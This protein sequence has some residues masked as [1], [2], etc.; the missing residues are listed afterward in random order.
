MRNDYE[1]VHVI[2]LKVSN[3]GEHRLI[4]YYNE[5]DALNAV[6]GVSLKEKTHVK[7]CLGAN[8]QL[9]AMWSSQNGHLWVV[10]DQGDVFTNANIN[11][12]QPPFERLKFNSGSFDIK[13]NVTEVF[14]GQLN[15]IWGTSDE[16]V[17][18][19]AFA[20]PAF[21][22]DG[23][24]WTQYT[25]PKAPNA[26]DGSASD[27][28]YVVGYDGNIH[29]FNGSAWTKIALPSGIPQQDAFTD[30]KVLS[31][32]KVFI[33]GRSGC[34]LVGNANN[35]FTDIGSAKYS[36]YGVGAIEERIFLAGGE[37]G[38]FELIDGQFVCL[39][40]K[41]QPVGVF[42]TPNAINFIPAEQQP[43]PWFVRYEPGAS[44]EWT[45]VNT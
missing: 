14:K 44:R 35:G 33:T 2:D 5:A 27:D 29:H 6:G 10:D 31:R 9:N 34:L 32:D 37:Q 18:V 45:K 17:W 3:L 25:L 22:W 4:T 11:F 15:A 16:D 1:I 19:T 23:Q 39:K 26:I 38:I 20:G 41:G 7:T 12:K 13:W 21:H 8:F 43:N 40:D 28:V 36:W 24:S 30:I 42:E